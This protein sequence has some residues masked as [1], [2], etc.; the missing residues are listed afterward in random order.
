[1]IP[2]GGAAGGEAIAT[3]FTPDYRFEVLNPPGLDCD[4]YI[5]EGSPDA[6][7]RPVIAASRT[8]PGGGDEHLTHFRPPATG[9]YYAVINR[10]SG[11]AGSVGFSGAD[12]TSDVV[13][14]DGFESGDTTAWTG[15]SP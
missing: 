2:T 12:I 5:Y 11:S 14:T 10:V 15:T 1:M 9:R 6:D 8:T 7:G 4:L 13:F 3:R